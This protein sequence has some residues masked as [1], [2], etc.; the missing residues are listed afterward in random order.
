[1]KQRFNLTLSLI[2]FIGFV[3]SGVVIYMTEFRQANKDVL[4]K[5]TMLMDMA[6]YTQS[7]ISREITPLLRE[8]LD[9]EFLPASV[10][11]YGVHRISLH[12]SLKKV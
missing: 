8:N 11:A 4:E 2:F 1:L 5:A 3:I 6:R 7:Y 10:P 12:T 9:E